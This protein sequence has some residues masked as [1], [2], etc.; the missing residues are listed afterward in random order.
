MPPCGNLFLYGAGTIGLILFFD[1]SG[2]DGCPYIE[3]SRVTL[4]GCFLLIWGFSWTMSAL[5]PPGILLRW[6]H[7]VR[8]AVFL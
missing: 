8:S 6:F 3:I 1:I 2:I 5:L 4:L 7:K